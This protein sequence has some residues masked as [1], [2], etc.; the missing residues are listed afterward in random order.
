MLFP[1]IPN[2]LAGFKV[3]TNPYMATT[4]YRQVRFPRSKK[5]RIRRKW[6]KQA[7]NFRT[8]DV[9]NVFAMGNTLVMHP[10]T[11]EKLKE[12]LLRLHE[13][14]IARE[15][16]EKPTSFLTAGETSRNKAT[17]VSSQAALTSSF[18]FFHAAELLQNYSASLFRRQ[19]MVINAAF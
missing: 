13:D 11:L 6:A 3:L 1:D 14:K 2:N 16:F 18:S 17:G 4:E 7:K 12:K 19:A 5:R 9:A 15:V 8:V 10:A